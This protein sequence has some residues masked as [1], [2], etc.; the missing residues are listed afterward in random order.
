MS[1]KKYIE[2]YPKAKDRLWLCI[3]GMI[4]SLSA[5][6]A[7]FI[8]NWKMALAILIFLWGS[9]IGDDMTGVRHTHSISKSLKE[10]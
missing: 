4:M 6:I 10:D 9:N 2:I 8:I 5:V 7:M 3:I 1:W